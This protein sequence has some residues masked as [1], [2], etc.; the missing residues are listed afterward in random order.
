MSK[1]LV[2]APVR[3]DLAGGTLDLWPLYLFSDG[4]RTINVAISFSVECELTRIDE[5]V[6][7]VAL[8]DV[9][10][11]QRYDSI[12][13]M[14]RD[15]S[16]RLLHAALAHFK[17]TGIRI[18]TRSDAPRGSGLGASSALAVALVRGLSELAGDPLEGEDLIAT[19]RDLETRLLGVPAGVQDYYPAVFGGLSTLRLEPG[20]IS[21]QALSYPIGELASSMIIHYSGVSHFSGTNNWEIYKR[22]IDGEKKVREG[23]ARIAKTASSMERAFEE[24]NIEE[25]AALLDEEWRT[26]K[27]LFEGVSTPEL[28][29]IIATARKAGAF[30]GKVCGAGGGGCV[31]ILTEP[32][33]RDGVVDALRSAPGTTLDAVP[34]S[35][36]LT[37]EAPDDSM[38]SRPRSGWKARPSQGAVS[39]EQLWLEEVGEQAVEPFAMAR[40]KLT[41]DESRR[42]VVH[43]VE[44]VMIAPIDPSMER[45]RWSE[46]VLRESLEESVTSTPGSTPDARIVD[47]ALRSLD[48]AKAEL[49]EE[50]ADREKLQAWFN[51]ELGVLSGAGESRTD[52][53]QRCL[54]LARERYAPHYARLESTLRLSLDQVRERF[55]RDQR[56]EEDERTRNHPDQQSRATAIPW[57]QVL[58]DITNGKKLVETGDTTLARDS[59]DKLRQHQKTWEREKEQ[60]DEQV[61]LTARSIERVSLSLSVEDVK[62]ESISLL[63]SDS[64]RSLTEI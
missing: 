16:V 37:T 61:A 20:R 17:L 58:H 24:G 51:P 54:D 4:A 31:I 41:F 14:S 40:V 25:V 34:V 18:A 8:L 46:G 63:W 48:G 15:E 6:V 50:I 11:R 56:D 62:V 13:E 55:D 9:D 45:V 5:E 22:A 3:A 35:F 49:C 60:I 30:A 38:T 59:W 27:S 57:G 29:E 1:L 10:Y 47:G 39:T 32:D 12:A 7:E 19:V 21:R 64:I 53:A 42:G 36:G 33:R 43:T 52:F 2:R 23:L 44:R 28:D 26:R